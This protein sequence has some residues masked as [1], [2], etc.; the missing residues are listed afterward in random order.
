M[1]VCKRII[2]GTSGFRAK[3]FK[4]PSCLLNYIKKWVTNLEIF[5]FYKSAGGLGDDNG[6]DFR[7][8]IKYSDLKDLI[9]KLGEIG[10][11]LKEI[12]PNSPKPEK[13]KSY[14]S[15]EYLKFKMPI[16]EDINYEQPGH[17]ILFNNK[18]FIWIDKEYF[19]IIVSGNGDEYH[20]NK[21]LVDDFD[22]EICK[23]LDLELKGLNWDKYVKKE[24]E[25]D[26][27]YISKN[28]YSELLK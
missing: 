17:S 12:P 24:L 3:T 16:N 2:F 7:V 4:F 10:I 11:K 26:R 9:E 21:W 19:R 22:Y 6:E 8:P 28:E 20:R 5:Y 13:G 27:R 15:V 23:S 25:S 14:T 1:S 18:C